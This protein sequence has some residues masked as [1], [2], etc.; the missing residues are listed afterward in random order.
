MLIVIIL[1]TTGLI[2]FMAFL[3][4]LLSVASRADAH[5]KE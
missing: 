1:A 3:Y 5:L 2:G 4:A